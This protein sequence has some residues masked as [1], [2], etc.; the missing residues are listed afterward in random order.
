MKRDSL[1]SRLRQ[2]TTPALVLVGAEDRSLPPF[3]A[4][5]IHDLLPNSRYVEIPDAGH[6]TALE[7]PALVNEAILDFLA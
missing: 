6:L 2:I 1:Y 7:K 5:R 3:L 4:R